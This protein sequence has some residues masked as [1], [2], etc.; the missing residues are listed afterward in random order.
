M[1]TPT[2]SFA[3]SNEYKFDEFKRIFSSMNIDLEHFY[4]DISEIQTI[5]MEPIIRDKVVKAYSEL[6]RPIIVDHSGLAMKALNDLPQ[7]LN[8]QFW[9]VLKDQVCDLAH[10]LGDDRAEIIVYL[11]FCDGQKIYSVCQADEGR[12]APKPAPVGTFHLDRV[13]IPKGCSTTFAEMTETERDK[14]SYRKKAA[15]KL[16][17][18]LKD[19]DYGKKI[20]LK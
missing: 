11:G 5:D 3:T 6:S 10:R 13:F 16:I 15:E 14:I 19:I 20:G 1:K 4:V 8:K 12:I 7:G 18:V 9:D 17:K 2:L